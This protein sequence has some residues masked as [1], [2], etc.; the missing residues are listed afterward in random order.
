MSTSPS[1]WVS[2]WYVAFLVCHMLFL[3]NTYCTQLPFDPVHDEPIPGTCCH[4]HHRLPRFVQL[5]R[6]FWF[7]TFCI[8]SSPSGSKTLRTL[9]SRKI[10]RRSATPSSLS[11][12][13]PPSRV[14]AAWPVPLPVTSVQLSCRSPRTTSSKIVTLSFNRR[15]ITGINAK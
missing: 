4:Q 13:R 5:I 15:N 6:R 1:S 2:A 12:L 14:R 10:L 8:L 3:S 11:R 9:R 7:G